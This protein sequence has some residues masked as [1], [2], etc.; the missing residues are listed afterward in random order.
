MRC[1]TKKAQKVPE[2]Y[3]NLVVNWLW[4]NRRNSQPT[5]WMETVLCQDVG[6]YYLSNICNVDETPLPFEYLNGRT[7]DLIGSKTIWIKETQSGWD[8]RQASLVLCIFADGINR[9]PPLI[10]FDGKTDRCLCKEQNTYHPGVIVEL[11]ET[12]YMNDTLFIKYLHHY[13]IP[14]LNGRL[15]LFALDLCRSHKT[16]AVLNQ[17]R[18]HNIMSSLIPGGCTSLVQPLDVAINKPL[19]GIIRNLTD[20]GIRKWEGKEGFKNW[21]VGDGRILTTWYST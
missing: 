19:K 9:V 4:F 7:Y 6:R 11:N 18:K 16:P 8:K 2:D 14:A 10:I 15:T 20:D 13:L 3:R 21:S 12:A 5:T 1:I 17:L